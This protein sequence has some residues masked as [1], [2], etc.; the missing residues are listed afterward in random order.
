[1]E[2][3]IPLGGETT[4]EERGASLLSHERAKRSEG[5]FEGESPYLRG[6]A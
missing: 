4:L 3:R 6:A 5:G 2:K 1:M